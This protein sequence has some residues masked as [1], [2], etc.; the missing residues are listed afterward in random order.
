[1]KGIFL[2]GCGFELLINVVG[3]GRCGL[4]LFI[5]WVSRVV[6]VVVEVLCF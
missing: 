5:G 2:F 6:V 4:L 1:M 3:R